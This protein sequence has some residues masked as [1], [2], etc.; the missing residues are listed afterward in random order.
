[1]EK[2]ISFLNAPVAAVE[3]LFRVRVN[4]AKLCRHLTIILTLVEVYSVLTS[5]G[6]N[7]RVVATQVVIDRNGKRVLK[8]R[9]KKSLDLNYLI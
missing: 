1:V 4:K 3:Y 6:K 7:D 2:S 5:C 8:F 9:L